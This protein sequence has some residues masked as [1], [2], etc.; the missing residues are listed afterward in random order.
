MRKIT[1]VGL[2]EEDYDYGMFY[3]KTLAEEIVET[4]DVE[5][6]INYRCGFDG[7]RKGEINSESNYK[8]SH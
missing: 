6:V 5:D 1:S 8:R 3:I 4:F 2:T 7:I